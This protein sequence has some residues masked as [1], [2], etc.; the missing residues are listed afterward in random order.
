MKE[1]S[2]ALA[3]LSVMQNGIEGI[4][5]G[6]APGNDSAA[7]LKEGGGLKWAFSSVKWWAVPHWRE[8]RCAQSNQS[9]PFASRRLGD[10]SVIP[11]VSA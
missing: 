5:P 8:P 7:S 3:L 2:K 9:N 10:S 6:R 1:I 11:G 4:N